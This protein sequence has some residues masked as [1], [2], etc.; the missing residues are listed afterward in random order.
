MTNTT[1]SAVLASAAAAVVDHDGYVAFW[2]APANHTAFVTAMLNPKVLAES[3]SGDYLAQ[4]IVSSDAALYTRLEA[5]SES[6]LDA[7]VASLSR[8]SDWNEVEGK[9]EVGESD[10]AWHLVGVIEALRDHRR[11]AR[12][13]TGH[14]PL[15]HNPFAVLAGV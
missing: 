8:V 15:T 10:Y 2:S 1:A 5:L 6:E 13:Y 9:W 3:G 7:E 4:E 12:E 14:G 11:V